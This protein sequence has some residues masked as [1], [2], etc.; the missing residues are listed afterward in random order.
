LV[1]VKLE[2]VQNWLTLLYIAGAAALEKLTKLGTNQKFQ[3]RY[4]DSLR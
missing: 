3:V 4:L 1:Q 2:F